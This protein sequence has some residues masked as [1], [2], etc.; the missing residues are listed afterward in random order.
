MKARKRTHFVPKVVYRTAFAGVV[1]I[2]VAGTACGGGSSG[3]DSGPTLTV[4]CSFCG[5]VGV[6]AFTDAGDA[7]RDAPVDATG[8]QSQADSCNLCG[9]VAIIAFADASEGG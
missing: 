2:C 1:P 4:A 9:A 8:D 6:A 3:G 5:G 7:A